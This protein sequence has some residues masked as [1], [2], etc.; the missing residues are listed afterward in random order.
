[1][2]DIQNPKYGDLFTN[3]YPYQ[4]NFYNISTIPST[5]TYRGTVEI[6]AGLTQKGT[7]TYPLVHAKDVQIGNKESD[8]LND[9]LADYDIIL[10][11]L[12]GRAPSQLEQLSDGRSS[13]EIKNL[14]TEEGRSSDNNNLRAAN[15]DGLESLDKIATVLNNRTETIDD[16]LLDLRVFKTITFGAESELATNPIG[17]KDTIVADNNGD[18]I[19]VTPSNQW[20]KIFSN[21]ADDSFT[22]GHLVQ[23]IT[24]DVGS[25]DFNDT[26]VTESFNVDTFT[27]DAAGH[28]LSRHKHTYTMPKNF[29]EIAVATAAIPEGVTNTVGHVP[30]SCVADN[31]TDV[32]TLYAGNKWINIAANRAGTNTQTQDT[33]DCIT[34]SHAISALTA[35]EHKLEY[36]TTAQTPSF[37]G[38]FNIPKPV[39]S[40]TTDQAG[41][42]IAYSSNNNVVTVTIPQPSLTDVQASGSDVITQ[43]SLTAS[44]GAL[45]TTR[46]DIG[47][48]TLKGY[49]LGQDNAAVEATDSLNA[50]IAKLQKQISTEITARD[51][52]IN[53]AIGTRAFIKGENNSIV[54]NNGTDIEASG[55]YSYAEGDS[56]KAYAYAAHAEGVESIAA[57][58]GAHA[59]GLETNAAGLGSHTEGDHTVAW[60]KSTHVFGEYNVE[61]KVTE[62]EVVLQEQRGNYVEIVGNGDSTTRSNARTLDWSGNE[63]LAGSLTLGAGTVNEVTITAEKLNQLLQL[64]NGNEG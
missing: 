21:A 63:T 41:H 59:E 64:L 50:A 53:D 24:D 18:T 6:P 22:I 58:R 47:S 29:K 25:T 62:E 57:K 7:G 42:V 61:D 54:A 1:M 37:G 23:K 34:F 27:F 56:T 10:R 12:Y 40:F 19:T 52:A 15:N 14:N 49:Q 13:Q 48:L 4:K 35:G 51:T 26:N 30:G 60:H 17:N 36:S 32:L 8:R 39:C 55:Q 33:N 44:S 43:L 38:T 16:R 20:I 11:E 46:V 28:V 2:A 45:S 5:E 3:L 31:L 9:K